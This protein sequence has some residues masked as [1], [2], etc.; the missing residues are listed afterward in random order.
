MDLWCC[1]EKQLLLLTDLITRLSIQARRL[2]I[3][4]VPCFDPQLVGLTN[5]N[6]PEKSIYVKN[7]YNN[8]KFIRCSAIE[9]ARTDRGS[10]ANRLWQD[11]SNE[12]DAKH[13]NTNQMLLK[14]ARRETINIIQQPRRP[15]GVF[16][17]IQKVKHKQYSQMTE[18]DNR[19]FLKFSFEY[20]LISKKIKNIGKRHKMLIWGHPDWIPILKRRF[21]P[22]FLDATFRTVPKPFKQCLILMVFDN[23]TDLYIPPLTITIDFEKGL[24]SA[25]V[26]QFKNT[27]IIGCL[28]HYKKALR[29]KLI[30][31]RIDIEEI[32]EAMK[33]GMVDRLT[34]KTSLKR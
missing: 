17:I 33:P 26:K 18:C 29:R 27:H 30:K 6:P 28:F 25:C 10:S 13:Q 2:T 32:A 8:C 24:I 3:T 7:Y 31:L 19:L 4:D 21:I 5:L 11:I 20:E 14:I 23:K 15:K 12:I 9:R 22:I 1:Y 16:D 34:K